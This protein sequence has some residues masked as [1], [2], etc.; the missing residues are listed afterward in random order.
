[1][2]RRFAQLAAIIIFAF[3]FIALAFFGAPYLLAVPRQ[4]LFKLAV[5][6]TIGLAIPTM[7]VVVLLGAVGA[8]WLQRFSRRWQI[9]Q[10]VPLMVLSVAL[11]VPNVITI[12]RR[13]LQSTLLDSP[14]N[15][16]AAIGVVYVLILLPFAIW[17]SIFNPHLA[18]PS[19]GDGLSRYNPSDPKAPELFPPQAK[20]FWGGLGW[21]QTNANPTTEPRQNNPLLTSPS[22][23]EGPSRDNRSL[24]SSCHLVILSIFFI[25]LNPITPLL[26][27]GGEPYNRTHLWASWAFANAYV[28]HSYGQ[29][30]AMIVWMLPLLVICMIVVLWSAKRG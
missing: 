4:Y 22:L 11:L 29:A 3:L 15:G 13:S 30:A 12:L 20:R 14:I 27:T 18:S 17:L 5:L 23:G 19:L 9:A 26:L 1:M 28:G 21:G 7:A 10:L 6:N 25:L 8:R 24:Q 16:L 2:K